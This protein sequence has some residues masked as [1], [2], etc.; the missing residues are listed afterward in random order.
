MATKSLFILTEQAPV[1]IF[2]SIEAGIPNR[3]PARSSEC[4]I[5]QIMNGTKL[6]C[7]LFLLAS[8]LCAQDAPQLVRVAMDEN[9]PMSSKDGGFDL[10]LLTAMAELEDWE[11][12]V[13]WK[14]NVQGCLE[15]VRSHEADLAISGISITAEREELNDFSHPYFDSGIYAMIS[16][17]R[18]A[19][20]RKNLFAVW[21]TMR[22]ALLMFLGILVFFGHLIWLIERKDESAGGFSRGYFS[23]V[24]Q[25]IWWALV[26]SSTVGYGDIVPKLGRGRA[27]ACVMII[28][29]ITWFGLFISAMSSTFS[30]L[31]SEN[32]IVNVGDLAGEKAAT[33]KGSTSE[34]NLKEVFGV[35]V[36]TFNDINQAHE[37]L[38]EGKASVVIFD[39]PALMELA[40]K[41]NRVKIVG[42]IFPKQRYAIALPISSPIRESV[43]RALLELEENGKYDEIYNK[44][45]E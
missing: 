18:N 32:R 8:T 5:A 45:F 9:P 12:Q 44:W 39:A 23:G 43:N 42:Q 3:A 13:V 28:V 14:N 25:G 11:V 36:L 27:L 35:D 15:S 30:A 1:N 7:F 29:G 19:F 17:E 16:A 26:T 20:R 41:D 33:K 4:L 37:A 24:G 34:Q 40:R 21:P 38:L 31:L 2:S 6:T 10:D 22:N